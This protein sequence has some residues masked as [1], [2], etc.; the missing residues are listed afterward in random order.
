MT[1]VSPDA[2]IRL[3]AIARLAGDA[4]MEH[5]GDGGASAELKADRTPVT[6]ADK[7]A[8]R[9]IV[10]ALSAWDPAS[11]V[12][13]E[14]G[15]IPG[16]EVRGSWTSFWLVDP[17]D[18]TKEFIQRNGEFTVNI[19]RIE[20][21]EPV[22]G[23]VYAPALDVMYYAG[24]GLGAWKR[25]GDEVV[26][27]IGSRP[28]LPGH[29]VRVVESRS[30]PSKELEEWLGSIQVAERLA[31][32]SSL[33][34]CWVA[35]GRADVYPR[36]GPTME[37]DVAAGDCIFRSS[38]FNRQRRSALRYNQ[39]ELR[40]QGFVIGLDDRDLETDSGDGRVV[41]FTGLSGSGKSTI[42]RRV[43]E[44]LQSERRPVEYLDGDAIRD[45]FPATGFSR[46]EREAHIRRVGYLASRLERHGVTVVVS[47]IS[48]YE[49]SRQFVRGRCRHFIEVFVSTPLDECER[50]DVKGLY[51]KARRGEIKQ[52]TGIDDPYEPPRNPELTLE[53]VG[54]SVDAAVERVM[55]VLQPRGA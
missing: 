32:G 6:A 47:L 52:F 55:A 40:N 33:K 5:Y 3:T 53:T 50:R 39:P 19:A 15:T 12:V 20:H 28:P 45:I 18:G 4:L 9:V 31:V 42:A 26:T 13:S 8:H 16:P 11:P 7:A 30:H 54:V 38:G 49:A 35:E 41:W 34:F 29:A 48:P 1:L 51:A 10:D 27:R 23:V 17:L 36:F 46:E 44:I 2:L 25:E 22:L 24:R 14:E 21:G 43:V 37:W